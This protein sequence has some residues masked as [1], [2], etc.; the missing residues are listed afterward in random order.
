RERALYC[1]D[2]AS[3]AAHARDKVSVSMS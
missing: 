3:D 2:L 1:A